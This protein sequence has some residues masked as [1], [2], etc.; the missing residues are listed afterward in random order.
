MKST[1]LL[2][3]ILDG[4]ANYNNS[5]Y[6]TS[7][8]K[9]TNNHQKNYSTEDY[10]S[11]LENLFSETRFN[12]PINFRILKRSLQQ[13]KF[14]FA[15]FIKFICVYLQFSQGLLTKIEI[16][17]KQIHIY[18]FA[19]DDLYLKEIED[20]GYHLEL[21]EDAKNYLLNNFK[22]N[23][24]LINNVYSKPQISNSF[25]NMEN[26]DETSNNENLI[27]SSN[28]FLT[29]KNNLIR[30]VFL[31]YKN[32]V[33]KFYKFYE[34][35]T[36]FFVENFKL[37]Y[38]Q[39]ENEDFNSNY[40]SSKLNVLKKVDRMKI[41]K[42]MTSKVINFKFFADEG[43]NLNSNSDENLIENAMFCNNDFLQENFKE[44]M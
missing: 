30:N 12:S 13:I 38:Q 28:E 39:N 14:D 35:K 5:F 3:E 36:D 41:L 40:N 37:Y 2:Q 1:K 18:V 8:N 24:K 29:L 31:P 27:K 20:H 23:N 32:S 42:Y 43:N 9:S 16:I 15:N 34:T 11:I 44:N 6:N 26:A 10:K 33:I 21:S 7:N 19:D 25:N 22:D 17:G 4:F